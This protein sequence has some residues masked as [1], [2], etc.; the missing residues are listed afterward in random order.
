[1]T[2]TA[3]TSSETANLLANA[4]AFVQR[5]DDDLGW[6]R[7]KIIDQ[8][9]DMCRKLTRIVEEMEAPSGRCPPATA[10]MLS[11]AAQFERYL[12][13]FEQKANLLRTLHALRRTMAVPVVEAPA[14]A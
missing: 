11:D 1:M 13:E 9:N 8:A 6:A 10:S 5:A 3:S 7:S 14:A 4:D 12:V 2:N